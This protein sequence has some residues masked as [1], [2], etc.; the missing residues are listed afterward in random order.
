MNSFSIV[1]RLCQTPPKERR[2]TETPYNKTVQF[3]E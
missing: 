3:Y 2:L 1:G